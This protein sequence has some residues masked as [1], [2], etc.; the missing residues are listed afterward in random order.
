MG[1]RLGKE[2]KKRVGSSRPSQQST[3]YG[4]TSKYTT[5][6]HVDIDSK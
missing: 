6:Q 5:F 2:K 4:N 3:S 1:Q